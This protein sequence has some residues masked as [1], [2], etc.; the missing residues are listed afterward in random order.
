MQTSKPL[1]WALIGNA[2]FSISCAGIVFLFPTHIAVTLGGQFEIWLLLSI[3]VGLCLFAGELLYQATR[4]RLLTLRALVASAADFMWVIGTVFLVFFYSH[5]F[6]TAGLALVAVIAVIVLIFGVWQFWAAG[7]AHRTHVRGEY[8]HCVIVKVNVPPSQMWAVV[9]DLGGI[10][11]YMPSLRHSKLI[12]GEF[13]GHGAIRQCEDQ[14]GKRWR[15]ECIDYQMGKEFTL[16]F[17]A[18]APDFPFPARAMRGGWKV[19]SEDGATNVMVWWEL[20]PKFPLLASV[21]LPLM[22]FQVDRDFPEL[23]TRM[24]SAAAGQPISASN[25]NKNIP[26]ARLIQQVC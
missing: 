6:S 10:V 4:P 19:I 15:E 8:R 14:N 9:S 17:H 16:R 5:L 2:L 3:A 18:E 26:R 24:A 21:I 25:T 23:I 12:H 1:R 22:A 13:V 7:Y 11:K 20:T